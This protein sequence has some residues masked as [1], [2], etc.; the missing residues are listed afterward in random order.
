MDVL[1]NRQ[2]A[3]HLVVDGLI[4]ASFTGGECLLPRGA[5]QNAF[6]FFWSTTAIDPPIPPGGRAKADQL[7]S[8]PAVSFD[9]LVWGEVLQ[10]KEG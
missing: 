2:P 7:A 6:Y 4:M 9:E 1:D 5:P 10:W 3:K 8:L